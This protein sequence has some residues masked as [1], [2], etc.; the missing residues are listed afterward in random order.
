MFLLKQKRMI[1]SYALFMTAILLLALSR[2][3]ILA[4]MRYLQGTVKDTLKGT[5]K[6]TVKET[7][8]NMID[9]YDKED[10]PCRTER[11]LKV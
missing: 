6:G 5:V 2:G 11:H 1:I 9:L 8:P 3:R 4:R 7:V 10:M